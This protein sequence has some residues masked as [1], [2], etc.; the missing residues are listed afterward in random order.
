MDESPRRAVHLVIPRP[1]EA[2]RID[3]SS[4]RDE[5][6]S[7][8]IMSIDS[9]DVAERAWTT[10]QV[11]RITGVSK[12]RLSYWLDREILT[13]D[14]D[15]ARGR[16]RVRLW[17]FANLVEVRVVVWLR[18]RVSLQL[19]AKIVE[20]LRKRGLDQPL[21]ELRF[22]VVDTGKAKRP[23]DVVVQRPDGS[24]ETPIEGQVVMEVLLPL[25]R[26][27]EELRAASEQDRAR[28]RQPGRVERRRGR[29][30]SVEVLAGTRVPVAAVRRLL[31]AGWSA[32]RIIENHPGLTDRDV[33]AAVETSAAG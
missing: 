18:D 33:A 32:E 17:S 23:T 22:A 16:G 28:R 9:G 5:T 19:I 29:L 7:V 21:A 30:G 15:E 14:V 12:R 1:R 31:A 25:N 4:L 8:L 13:A 10:E 27:A 26:F 11:L 3:T 20:N 2:G 6:T 24:W